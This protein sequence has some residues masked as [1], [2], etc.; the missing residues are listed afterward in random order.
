MLVVPDQRVPLV[1][2]FDMQEQFPTIVV[3][4]ESLG[5]DNALI[6]VWNGSGW[7]PL[8]E[9]QFAS[10]A[11]LKVKPLQC[12]ILEDGGTT[13]PRLVNAARQFVPNGQVFSVNTERTDNML[14]ALATYYGFDE[15][16]LQY[17]S[18]QYGLS[19]VDQSGGRAQASWYDLPYQDE[20]KMRGGLL[21]GRSV[22]ERRG[23]D[24]PRRNT[25]A[26]PAPTMDRPIIQAG[27]SGAPLSAQPVVAPRAQP[28]PPRSSGVIQ[29][30]VAAPVVQDTP[31]RVNNTPMVLPSR[32]PAPAPAPLNGGGNLNQ[33]IE[34]VR[35]ALFSESAEAP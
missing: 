13:P 34:D 16:D 21:S 9:S 20:T 14:N 15:S 28:T 17:F 18:Q 32:D 35:N 22:L 29:V 4:Y 27:Q 7:L 1:L 26:L 23:I 19:V 8:S 10:G 31:L 12:M 25:P 6:H 2:S 5:G 33:Q 30:P 24:M 3:S 11:F